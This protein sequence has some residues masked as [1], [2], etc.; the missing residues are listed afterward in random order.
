MGR[1]TTAKNNFLNGRVRRPLSDELRVSRAGAL[2]LNVV[3]SPG[4]F[5]R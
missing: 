3:V 1:M 2:G 4:C 5:P